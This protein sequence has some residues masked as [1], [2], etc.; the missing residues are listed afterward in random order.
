MFSFCDDYE[1]FDWPQRI[2]PF[3][4]SI[5]LSSHNN[6]YIT[7]EWST[8]LWGTEASKAIPSSLIQQRSKESSWNKR[9]KCGRALGDK[10]IR[11]I[12]SITSTTTIQFTRNRISKTHSLRTTTLN[13]CRGALEARSTF[14]V[15]QA[16]KLTIKSKL[17]RPVRKPTGKD[18]ICLKQEF[19]TGR[20][21]I[22]RR[23]LTLPTSIKQSAPSIKDPS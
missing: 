17:R 23:L 4:L 8:R 1:L 10:P 2:A 6:F 22:R 7:S 19:S 21:I 13:T 14:K 11:L 20:L 3:Y 16:P 12:L 5:T 15:S 18:T 9:T